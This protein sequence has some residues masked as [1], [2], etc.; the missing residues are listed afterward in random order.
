MTMVQAADAAM[1]DEKA[2]LGRVGFAPSDVAMW[3]S[4]EP[5]I[6]NSF[7][8]DAATCSKFWGLSERLRAQLPG[9]S[10]RGT[11]E[12]AAGIAIHRKERELRERFLAAHVE[13]LYGKLTGEMSQFI[14][15]DQLVHDAARLLPGLTP[16]SKAMTA[17][18]A[19]ALKAKEGLE[20][21]HGI[22]LSH[23]LAHAKTGQHLCHAM[24][25]PRPATLELL[26]RMAKEGSID[27]GAA[28]VTRSGK[29]SIVEL[30]NPTALNAL[31]ETM[32]GPLEIATDL[33]ILDQ[34]TEIAVM[35]GG[36]VAHPK[37]AGRR[38]YSSGLNLTHLYQGKIS[39]LLYL[40]H[41]MGYEHKVF[42][43][44]ATPDATPD[45][46][47]G[48][49][50]E[51]PWIAAVETFAIGGGCQDLLVMDYVLA[52]AG[53]YLTLPARK[54]G[55]IPGVANMRLPRF[56]GDRLA[57]QA[58]MH[59]RRFDCDSHDGRLICDEIAATGQMDA[60]LAHA[61]DAFTSSGVVS[62]VGNRRH[63]RI[64]QEPLDLFRR[65]V[66]LYAREQA[67]CHFSP[68]L[69]ANLERHWMAKAS[70][71]LTT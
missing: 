24:L 29:A 63:F 2:V 67:Y 62:A 13:E 64:A 36:R 32:V 15:I 3:F 5:E 9:K 59:D 56:V 14:R 30:R 39:L 47:T 42:R 6:C 12:A 52:E 54:E 61:I 68:A 53:T 45:D 20:I 65:Y 70:N 37:Y 49:T 33:A 57:R 40:Q 41:V 19:L 43:G 51:K 17:E 69:I 7:D 10:A 27:L 48:S 1:P 28:C 60:A 35:R 26:P 16:S 58:I 46:L 50:V 22:L 34:T 44:L 66:A 4:A 55:I 25:L 11:D 18:S 8:R 71:T 38:I 21:D 31:D 23:I